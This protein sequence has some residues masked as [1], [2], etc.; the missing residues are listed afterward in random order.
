M[1]ITERRKDM[2][3]TG[4]GLLSLDSIFDD[5]GCRLKNS[6]LNTRNDLMFDPAVSI[7]E[8]DAGYRISV[9]TPGVKSDQLS[10]SLF[11][12]KLRIEGTRDSRVPYESKQEKPVKFVKEIILTRHINSDNI[13]ANYENGVLTININ[14]TKPVPIKIELKSG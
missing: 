3:P 5:F 10:I 11:G 6:S 4:R 12:P 2:L 1:P 14:K 7:Y 13:D 9:E 8:T